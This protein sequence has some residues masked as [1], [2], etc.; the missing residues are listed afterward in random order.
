MNRDDQFEQRLSR[1]PVRSVPPAWR[2][3]ILAA[4]RAANPDR[5]PRIPQRVSGWRELF[6]PHP[7]AWATLA[8]VWLL[9]LGGQIA[10]RESAP[11]QFARQAAPSPE[12]RALLREQVRLYAELAGPRESKPVD[13]PRPPVP[14]PHGARRDE[15][16]NV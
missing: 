2:G 12:M 16:A 10:L 4:A 11:V 7:V 1:Q 3:E 15:T 8:A 5:A 14:R 6:W 9:I 13:R